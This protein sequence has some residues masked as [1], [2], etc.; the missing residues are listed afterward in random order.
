MFQKI[1][2]KF[3]LLYTKVPSKEEFR[4]IAVVQNKTHYLTCKK[5]TDQLKST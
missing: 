1:I 5:R 2:S 4:I 3:F